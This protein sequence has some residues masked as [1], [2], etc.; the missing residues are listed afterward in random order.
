[1]AKGHMKRPQHRLRSITPRISL[2]PSQE[3][4]EYSIMPNEQVIP[5][6]TQLPDAPLLH[7]PKFFANNAPPALHQPNLI[8]DD[9]IDE[10]IANVFTFGAFANKNSGIVYH[11]LTGSFLFMSLDGNVC[12]PYCTITNQIASLQCR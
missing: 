10:F 11:Y 7:I 9:K 3:A 2:L 6:V 8:V 5:A 4:I 1:M 12:F